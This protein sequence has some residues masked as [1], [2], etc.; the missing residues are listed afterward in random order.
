MSGR[1]G[2]QRDFIVKANVEILTI[3]SFQENYLFM[4][5]CVLKRPVV[6]IPQQWL[7]SM[8]TMVPQSL[9]KGRELLVQKL[10]EEVTE[11]YGKSMRRFNG[12]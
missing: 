5:K 9:M 12:K 2:E 3:L 8:L 1:N 11:D 10:T 6:P 7:T 4:K